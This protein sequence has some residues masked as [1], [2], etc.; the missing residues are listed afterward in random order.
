MARKKEAASEISVEDRLKNLFQL[1]TILSEIDDIRTLADRKTPT[2]EIERSRQ[3]DCTAN[4]QDG[5]GLRTGAGPFLIRPVSRICNR[6][7]TPAN[8]SENICRRIRA[9]AH[10]Q[11]GP[12]QC[13]AHFANPHFQE[14]F[15]WFAFILSYPPV[16][17][18]SS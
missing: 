12:K 3:S 13:H 11:H 5:S 18:Q 2:R 14:S 10:R 16:K 17:R 1:Q 7:G 15:L 8:P 9:E 4:V 6:P